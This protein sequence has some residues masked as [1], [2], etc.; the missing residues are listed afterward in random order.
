MKLL[1]LGL[2]HHH[3]DNKCL[4][5]FKTCIAKNGMTQELVPLACRH[6]NIAKK[7]IQTMKNHFVSLLGRVYDRFPLSMWCHLVW[8]AELTINLLQQSNVAPKVSVYAHVHGQHHYM[9]CP[10]AFL[11]CAVIAHVKPQNRQS[12]DVHADTGFNIGMAMEHH[13]CFHIYIMKTKGDENQWH[14]VLQT[15]IYHK[16]SGH[17]WNTRH[18]GGIRRH[19]CIKWNGLTRW[20]DRRG[21][22]NFQ[23]VIHKDGRSKNQN[24]QKQKSNEITFKITPMTAKL[25]QFQGWPRDHLPQQAH[26]QGCW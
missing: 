3:L 16:P 10:F 8:P 4:A 17:T 15:P 26:F 6:P 23:R 13:R 21:T 1:E 19:K 25:Y 18:K 14:S 5:E 11:G 2:K 9:K 20:Q 24:W 12:W 22:P 7:A